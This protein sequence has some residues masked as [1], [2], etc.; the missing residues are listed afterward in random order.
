MWLLLL[1]WRSVRKVIWEK[2]TIRLSLLLICIMRQCQF[3]RLNIQRCSLS[4]EKPMCRELQLTT[5]LITLIHKLP[6]VDMI[7]WR[8]IRSILIYVSH[9]IWI[10]LLKGWNWLPCTRSTCTMRYM[11]IRTVQSLL[12]TSWIPVFLT[13]WTDNPF[14]NVFM[15]EVTC[16][17]IHRKQVVIRKLTWKLPWIMTGRSMTIIVS[18]HCSCSTS[19]PSCCIRKE[20]WKMRFL[21]VWWVLPVVLLIHGKTVILQNSTS[22][23]TVPRTSRPNIVSEL[24]LHLVWDGLSQ[25]R[26]SGNRCQKLFLSWRYAI[27]M[28]K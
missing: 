9:R 2:E 21:I 6:V 27:R 11:Y 5:I 1:K 18:V 12:I 4:T 3:H 7:T 19:N 25:T 16:W 15:K 8:K 24:S 26:N 17:A 28:V 14:C 23:I 20:H 10:C 22:V 13:I